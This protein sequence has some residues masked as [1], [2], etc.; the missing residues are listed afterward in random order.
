MARDQVLYELQY[1][2]GDPPP[3]STSAALASTATKLGTAALVASAKASLL[4]ISIAGRATA[5]AGSYAVIAA[6]KGLQGV[7][8]LAARSGSAFLEYSSNGSLHDPFRAQGLERSLDAPDQG[9]S[10]AGA[11]A[12]TDGPAAAPAPEPVPE[13]ETAGAEL[14][15]EV[16]EEP[17]RSPVRD[18]DSAETQPPQTQPFLVRNAAV[19]LL[20]RTRL[21]EA[22]SQGQAGLALFLIAVRVQR[23]MAPPS[24]LSTPAP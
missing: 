13:N 2:G 24:P 5:V 14:A 22:A 7:G 23:A 4:A 17:G 20:G 16:G 12:L 1:E 15:S 10:T 9:S 3:P 8:S 18:G 11:A 21:H 19:D 6:G